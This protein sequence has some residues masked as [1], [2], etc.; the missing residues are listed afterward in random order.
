MK[1]PSPDVH[2]WA[3]TPRRNFRNV[4]CQIAYQQSE[5]PQLL[6]KQPGGEFGRCWKKN[7]GVVFL[8]GGTKDRSKNV[9]FLLGGG[10]FCGIL[11]KCHHNQEEHWNM[12]KKQAAGGPIGTWTLDS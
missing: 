9:F 7:N 2:I 5:N 3:A 8:L 11:D 1:H 6:E 4:R 12:V 10:L